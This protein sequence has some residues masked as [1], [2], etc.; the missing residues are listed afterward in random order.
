LTFWVWNSFKRIIFFLFFHLYLLNRS[1]YFK[2]I[3]FIINFTFL[4]SFIKTIWKFFIIFINIK[5]L[6][7]MNWLIT[8]K[9]NWILNGSFDSFEP[10]ILL[11]TKTWIKPIILFVFILILFYKLFL[12]NSLKE[13][14]WLIKSKI[15][16]VL[17]N[18]LCLIIKIISSKIKSKLIRLN[19]IIIFI[20]KLNLVFY[21]W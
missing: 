3:F 11:I 4:E 10:R 9:F 7:L 5:F 12:W 15:I 16:K 18:F 14:C 19:L 21:R 2:I 20:I 17:L 8:K 1:S 13:F 6:I